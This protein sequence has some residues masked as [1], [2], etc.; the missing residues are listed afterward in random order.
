MFPTT[1]EVLPEPL[2]LV[3]VFSCWNFPI[4]EYNYSFCR[5]FHFSTIISH[6][7]I[8]IITWENTFWLKE[9]IVIS[10]YIYYNYSFCRTSHVYWL[11]LINYNLLLFKLMLLKEC[12]RVIKSVT[13]TQVHM[14][15]W[16]IN[17]SLNFE[18]LILKIASLL[19]LW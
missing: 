16:L 2:G 17:N 12:K 19:C 10:N 1:G 5:S 11:K 4:C 14:S 7:I 6:I 9:E 15:L 18:H 8:F 3:L 13:R